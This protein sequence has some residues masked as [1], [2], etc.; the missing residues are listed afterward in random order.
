MEKLINVFNQF[1]IE[2]K[3]LSLEPHGEGHINS[4]F[5]ARVECG[6]EIKK[7]IFQKIN[8]NLFTNVDGLMNNIL[9]VTSFIKEKAISQGKNPETDCLCLIETKDGKPFVKANDEYFR[10]Y[11]FIDGLSF[12]T[13]EN[14]EQFYQ[15]AF[16]FGEFAKTLADF[17][18]EQLYEVLPNFHNTEKRFEG[19]LETLEKDPL[20]RASSVKDEI[21]FVIKRKDYAKKIV[22]LLESGKMP[23]KVTHNDTKLNN[24]MFDKKG[25]KCLAVIDLDTIMPGS[26]CYD[27]GDSIRFGCNHALEDEKDLTKVNFDLELFDAYARGYLSAIGEGITNIERKNLPMGAILMT[28]ECGMR[29]LKD[30][31]DGDV[32]FRIH[33]E[34]HNLDRA[35]TQFKLVSDMEKVFDKMQEIIEKY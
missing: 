8:S 30:H 35:R 34:N 18:A 6:G 31:L 13:V 15:S 29:F 5:L 26:L 9:L 32:Y 21:D 20:G 22:S 2:G 16:A 33:R 23:Y 27:F 4:T 12:Q 19:F 28:Y 10:V 24:V 14:K 1:N 25:E 7:Y 3:L 17:N 11:N